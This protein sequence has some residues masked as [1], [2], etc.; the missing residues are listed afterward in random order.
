MNNIEIKNPWLLLIAIPLIAI[1]IAGFF[2]LPKMK[3][4]KGKNI[5]S[6]A[7]H[8]VMALTLA[9]AFSD[10]QILK[11]GSDTEVYVVADCSA[12]NKENI[13][14]IDELIDESIKKASEQPNT[15]VGVIAF[16]KEAKVIT[17]P[18][19]KFKTV[20]DVFEDEDF[21][22]ATDIEN[23][24]TYTE[25]EFSDGVIKRMI[26]ISDGKETDGD[27]LSSVEALS[28]NGITIDAISLSD[29]N[30][31]EIAVT[32]LDYNDHCFVNRNETVKATVRSK[33]AVEAT[34][35]ITSGGLVKDSKSVSLNRGINVISFNVD[36]SKVGSVDYTFS[37]DAKTN[38][39]YTEN[40]SMSFT[41]DYTDELDVLL[42][43]KSKT[44][45]AALKAMD[46]YSSDKVKI[47]Q[48]VDSYNVPYKIEDLIKYDEIILSDFSLDD[49]NHAKQFSSNLSAAVYTYGKS[50]LT[51]QC[52]S[53]ESSDAYVETYNDMLP[54]QFQSDTAKAVVF[55]IDCSGSMTGE[56]LSTAKRGTIA[57]LD[58]L[59]ETDYVSIISFESEVH[60]LQPM[61]SM[62][63]KSQIVKAINSVASGGST[64]MYAGMQK[65]YAQFD[66]LNIGYKTVICLT[67]GLPSDSESKLKSLVYRMGSESIICSFINIANK[68]GENLLRTLAARGN[69]FYRYCT[70]AAS[71][72]NVMVTAMTDNVSDTEI[73]T[74]T[75][76][77]INKTD[78]SVL[79]DV[80]TLPQIGGYV[81]CHI[82]TAATT[83]MTV[84][85]LEED[86]QGNKNSAIVPLYAYW[87]F[88]KGKVSSFTSSLS[89]DWSKALFA[90]QNGAKFLNNMVSDMLPDRAADNAIDLSYT[91][92]G[93]TTNISLNANDGQ[94]DSNVKVKVT[95]PSGTVTEY[96]ALYDG[97]DYSTVI[98]TG[99]IGKYILY[100]SYSSIQEDGN[101]K[102]I[103]T[104]QLPLYFDYSKEYNVF[105]DNANTLMYDI[106]KKANG[107]LGYDEVIY[108]VSDVQ[109]SVSSYNSTMLIFILVTVI[110]FLVDIAIRKTDF[111]KKAKNA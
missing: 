94:K 52:K 12:S 57:C 93:S 15:S 77:L 73:V 40:N 20:E 60:I 23:A 98:T 11:V 71:L 87:N 28:A 110:L 46:A 104:E 84:Q 29:V 96:V 9:L 62:K 66:N 55:L 49:I 111:R 80:G 7:I 64:A 88:G 54:I 107:D 37:I 4:K 51:F 22:S 106:A 41:Q 19:Q 92:N 83:V 43:T 48:Y 59:S 26:L 61:T 14:K 90:N 76:I 17:K 10:I 63:N 1:V 45:Y 81:F 91:N 21:T 89:G 79:S 32:A 102:E 47:T 103:A 24:L 16:G 109:L 72:V 25:S 100:I 44:D 3:R 8:I 35:K 68:S 36:T 105:D 78:D 38:D 97:I 27:A 70:S 58:S 86:E 33:K 82:K 75:D 53:G 31:D 42:I 18:G 39:T 50:V 2:I 108:N 74:N 101:C 67:D 99:E 56:M 5:A 6:L 30:G 34:A 13:T 85:Y 69:G 95:S 65:A